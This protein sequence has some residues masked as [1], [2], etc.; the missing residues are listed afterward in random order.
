M[1]PLYCAVVGISAFPSSFSQLFNLGPVPNLLI[2]LSLQVHYTGK[3]V[4][5]NRPPR[6]GFVATMRKLYNPLGFAKG[7]N[8]VL[9]TYSFIDIL[10][11][12]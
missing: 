7:Y 3:M 1:A 2:L 12:Y 4:N 5:P 8:F 10:L 11:I 9:C 6:N